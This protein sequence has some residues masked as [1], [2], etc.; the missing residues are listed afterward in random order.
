MNPRILIFDDST[1]SVDVETEYQI[2]LALDRLVQG[3]TTFIIAQKLSSVRRANV[4]LVVDQARVIAQ[5]THDELLDICPTYVDIIAS[6]L[7]RDE[8]SQPVGVASG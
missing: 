3:R 6:Q 1:S 5:G 4:I 7:I 8:R 2:Q